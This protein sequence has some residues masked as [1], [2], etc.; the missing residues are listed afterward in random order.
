VV[1]ANV[2]VRALEKLNVLVQLKLEKCLPERLPNLS[3]TRVS[4]LPTIEPDGPN[5]LI[6]VINDTLDHYRRIAIARLFEKFGQ[7]SFPAVDIFL[8]RSFA[9]GLHYVFCQRKKLL[10]EI[11]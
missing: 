5:N 3:F 6:D 10:Q 8:L 7:G 9:L 11:N 2:A 1:F 4:G